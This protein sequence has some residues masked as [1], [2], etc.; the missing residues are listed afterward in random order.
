L[1][2]PLGAAADADFRHPGHRFH[3]RA[4]VVLD[5]VAHQRQVD[6]LRIAWQGRYAIA[7][8]GLGRGSR[9]DHARLADVLG[10]AAGPRQRIADA[11]L[12]LGEVDVEGE[13]EFDGGRAGASGGAHAAQ[14]GDVAQHLFLRQRDVFFHVL[15][16]GTGPG[17]LHLDHTGLQVGNHLH[18]QPRQGQQAQHRQQQRHHSHQRAVA[19]HGGVSGGRLR[20]RV[21]GSAHWGTF[22]LR[23]AVRAVLGTARRCAHG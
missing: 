16:R 19:H 2:L 9:G 1:D 14:T 3:A 4:H 15:R 11:D 12:G 20:L 6:A 10:V 7:Q 21:D 23:A 5:E 13:F 22:A 18:R 17:G 8:K